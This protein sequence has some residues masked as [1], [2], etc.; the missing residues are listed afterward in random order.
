MLLI[1]IL[2]TLT[3][4]EQTLPPTFF[5][6][7]CFLFWVVVVRKGVT[8]FGEGGGGGIS[9]S[10]LFRL[11]HL[12]GNAFPIPFLPS[13]WECFSPPVALPAVANFGA[14]Q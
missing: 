7:F 5:T 13:L 2:V 9:P 11:S 3:E 6:Y 4:L 8:G 1:R 14:D 12:S 10:A